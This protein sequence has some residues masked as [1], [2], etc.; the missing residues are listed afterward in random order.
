MLWKIRRAS[1]VAAVCVAGAT[2][3]LAAAGAGC[4]ERSEAPAPGQ[5]PGSSTTGSAADKIG[6]AV[7]AGKEQAIV[8]AREGLQEVE[9]EISELRGKVDSAAAEKKPELERALNEAQTRLVKLRTKLGEMNKQSEDGW[10]KFAED[11]QRDL[12]DL[13]ATLEKALA[14]VRGG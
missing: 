1:V 12:G 4:E 10:R 2:A 7:A 13:R 6:A 5:T 14:E 11:F 3:V 9:K 8:K